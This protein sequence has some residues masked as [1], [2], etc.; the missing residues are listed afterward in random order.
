MLKKLFLLS[1][2]V[3]LFSALPLFAEGELINGIDGDFKP[4]AYMEPGGK[5]AGFD[6]DALNWIAQKQGFTVVHEALPWSSIIT[7]LKEKKI[8]IIAS[9]LSVSKER[10]EQVAFTIPYWVVKQVVVV[11]NNSNLTL[12]EVLNGGK[13]IG[14]QLGTSEAKSMIDSNKKDGRDYTIRQYDNFE[15]AVAE[16]V[17]GRIDAA[18]M[19]DAPA[20]IAVKSQ[21][22]KILGDAGIP[23]EQFAYAVN[24]DNPELLSTLNEGL[25]LLMA[26]PYWQTLIEKYNPAKH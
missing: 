12:D 15:M 19:N 2:S 16:V 23:E 7:S 6:V 4:F 9:G 5:A 26:D 24:K 10:A 3:L 21:P 17:N 14:V 22:V 18:V 13:T 11:S 25:A 20:L 1:F 8:D